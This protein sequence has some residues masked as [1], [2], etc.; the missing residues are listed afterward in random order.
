MAAGRTAAA[1]PVAATS[2]LASATTAA[3]RSRRGLMAMLPLLPFDER[4]GNARRCAESAHFR[5]TQSYRQARYS[6]IDFGAL[7]GLHE[8]SRRI[9]LLRKE[10]LVMRTARSILLPLLLAA[11]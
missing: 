5:I 3:T 9:A 11:G 2:M 4:V 1:A 8:G 7:A 6:P 10:W